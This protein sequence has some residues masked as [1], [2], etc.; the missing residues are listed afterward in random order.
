MEEVI[1]IKNLSYSYAKSNKDIL[2]NITININQGQIY[3]LLGPSG[4]GKTTMI[5][6]MTGQLQSKK[7]TIYLLGEDISEFK[8]E[9]YQRVGIMLDSEAFYDRL[10]CYNNLKVFADIH[11]IHTSSITETL[12]AVGLEDSI[13]K[14]VRR[15]STGMKQRL[16]LARAIIHSPDIIFLDEPTNGLDPLTAELIHKL[17]FELRDNGTTIFMTTHNM[18]EATLLCDN[19]GLL[20]EGK[21]VENDKPEVIRRKYWHDDNI[22]IVFDDGSKRILSIKNDYDEMILLL[23]E[24]VASVHSMEPSLEDV[25]KKIVRR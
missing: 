17:I 4:A 12:K 13:S 7:G 16:S 23:K 10:S 11:G 2:E 6:L 25:F 15:L 14:P 22:K 24:N 19:I 21:L 5:R 8:K 18:E 1:M 9:V 20:Y 3:G